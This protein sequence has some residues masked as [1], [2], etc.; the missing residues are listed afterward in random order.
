MQYKEKLKDPR[1]K[2]LAKRVYARDGYRCTFNCNVD[3]IPLV[4]HHRVYYMDNKEF[5]EPWDY[6]LDDMQTLCK[7]CHDILHIDFGFSM[8][9]YDKHTLKLINE[10]EP[11]RRTRLEIE[12]MKRKEKSNA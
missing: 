8:P 7:S 10:D 11:S 4:A 9:I 3:G 1:W 6:S 5:I 2:N 12:K